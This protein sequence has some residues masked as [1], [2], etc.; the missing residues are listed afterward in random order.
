MGYWISRLTRIRMSEN[1]TLPQFDREYGKINSNEI[2]NKSK[3]IG[4]ISIL[5]KMKF[6][7]IEIK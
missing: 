7:T 3:Q 6:W 4:S 2:E 5:D 1:I